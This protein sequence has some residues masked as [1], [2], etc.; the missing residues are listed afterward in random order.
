MSNWGI[1]AGDT[2]NNVVSESIYILKVTPQFIIFD[3]YDDCGDLWRSNVRR[4]V[5]YCSINGELYIQDCKKF[6][7]KIK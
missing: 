3:S 6:R 5:K 1:T 7:F 2:I 4:K